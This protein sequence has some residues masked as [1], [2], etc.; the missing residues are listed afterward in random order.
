MPLT[1]R[2]IDMNGNSYS[3]NSNSSSNN[4]SNN[5]SGNVSSSSIAY[6]GSST[7]PSGGAINQSI[8]KG[9]T[10]AVES[11]LKL[12]IQFICAK[13][14][15][16]VKRCVRDTYFRSN[17]V[18]LL[19]MILLLFVDGHDDDGQ[20]SHEFEWK[21]EFIFNCLYYLHIINAIMYL[22]MWSAYRNIFTA[23]VLP[24]WIN[25]IASL[26][27]LAS[28]WIYPLAFDESS[29]DGNVHR[30][31]VRD[32]SWF[33]IVRIL[34]IAAALLEL[35]ATFGYNIQWFID[36]SYELMTNPVS[37]IGRGFTLDDPDLWANVTL[38]I[39]A[40]LYIKYNFIVLFDPDLYQSCDM[41]IVAD[42]WYT[43]NAVFYLICSMRDADLFWFMPMQGKLQDIGYLSRMYSLINHSPM[44]DVE[45]PKDV[46]KIRYTN[47]K[48]SQ[49]NMDD[50]DDV[51]HQQLQQQQLQQQ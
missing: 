7:S 33:R 36:Y 38:I 44:G 39:S 34:E 48:Y 35:I 13:F 6:S 18:Y 15:K 47:G 50:D 24:D 3:S 20:M 4:S 26:L 25:L 46:N 37:L 14:G 16:A 30:S 10:G 22:H 1:I 8:S 40:S 32:V 5:I 51:H 45:L 21:L 28:G 23:F 31:L 49:V 42:Q 41:Y 17:L 9:I 43:I 29:Y 27:Y 11:E 19:Y 2:Q 12:L